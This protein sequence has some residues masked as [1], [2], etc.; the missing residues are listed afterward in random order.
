MVAE[1]R[2]DR[3]SR[4]ASAEE[5]LVAGAGQRTKIT[6]DMAEPQTNTPASETPAH[7]ARAVLRRADR[8][9]LATSQHGWP[10][11]SLVL[12]AL[13]QDGTPLLL[14]SDL[15]EHAKNIK[16]DPRI[17][18][19][20]DGTQG[21]DDPLTGPRVTVLGEAHVTWDEGLRRRFLAR[22]PSADLYAGFKDFQL[23]R[24]TVARAHLVAGFGRIHWIEARDFLAAPDPSFGAEE[25]AALADLNS[26]ADMVNIAVHTL[27]LD[28][29]GWR[30]TGID[31]EGLDLRRA[32]SIAR[33][34]FTAPA[35]TPAAARQ[36]LARGEFFRP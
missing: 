36:A 13:G 3:I 23:H 8:A 7:L 11:A 22:H 14:I 33:A 28:G 26:D 24:V 21:L 34:T 32:G 5:S 18:L 4:V 25:S 9:A 29:T 15:S 6:P 19:L 31:P 12:A 16:G 17:S 27:G 20:F 35:P 10:F 1:R 2:T 30:F